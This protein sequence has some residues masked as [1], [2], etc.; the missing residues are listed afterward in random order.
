MNRNLRL[1]CRCLFLLLLGLL[2]LLQSRRIRSHFLQARSMNRTSIVVN[3]IH[4]DPVLQV[5]RMAAAHVLVADRAIEFRDAS[6]SAN[7]QVLGALGF[8]RGTCCGA[9]GFAA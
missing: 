4:E 5:L 6:R 8:S 9:A 2:S 7:P 1:D 3:G